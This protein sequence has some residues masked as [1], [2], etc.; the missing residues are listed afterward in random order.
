MGTWTFSSMGRGVLTGLSPYSSLYP[1]Y[2]I[3]IDD[4]FDT[5]KAPNSKSQL[6]IKQRETIPLHTH[7]TVGRGGRTMTM[8]M[9]GE[10]G[11]AALVHIYTY[12][13]TCEHILQSCI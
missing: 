1:N 9:G 2:N 12:S 3:Q 4:S 5:S 6:V 8:T 7:P 11:Q 13:H 10:G